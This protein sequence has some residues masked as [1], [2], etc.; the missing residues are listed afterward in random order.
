M[1]VF[2]YNSEAFIGDHGCN[3]FSIDLR[4]GRVVYGYQGTSRPHLL[5]VYNIHVCE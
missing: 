5:I 2:Y 4:V 3:L 1:I